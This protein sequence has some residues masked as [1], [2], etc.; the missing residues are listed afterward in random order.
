MN[1]KLIEV[2]AKAV[3]YTCMVLTAAA[4]IFMFTGFV[5]GMPLAIEEAAAIDGCGPMR[6]FFSVVFPMLKPI[7]IPVGVLE[8]MWVWN[9]YLLPYLVLDR[10]KYKTIPIHIQYLQGS[11]G[12]VDLGAVMALIMISILPIIIFYLT[13]QKY[14]VSGV[15][16]GAVKG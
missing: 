13:C 16:A 6:T 5:K 2:M 12:H 8:I 4:L 11:Y 15:M 14:I 1:D 7:F 3:V 9:D 10:T